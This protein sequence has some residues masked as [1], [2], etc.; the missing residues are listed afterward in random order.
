M[1]M[2]TAENFRVGRRD[3]IELSDVSSRESPA[4]RNTIIPLDD[5]VDVNAPVERAV[6]DGPPHSEPFKP[7]RNLG[8]DM[9]VKKGRR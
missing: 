3:V 4:T 7:P 8:W 6:E 1:H 5:I 9:V 2:N